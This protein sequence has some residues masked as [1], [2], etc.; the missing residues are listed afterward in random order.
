[1]TYIVHTIV[2]YILRRDNDTWSDK[3]MFDKFGP[4]TRRLSKYEELH[5]PTAAWKTTF[6]ITCV[7][8]EWTSPLFCFPIYIYTKD[9]KVI[10]LGFGV[11]QPNVHGSIV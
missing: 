10:V 6:I 8:V 1:M 2:E 3:Y 9:G 7:V 11:I 4:G 5:L